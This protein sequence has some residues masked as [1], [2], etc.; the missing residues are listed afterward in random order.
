MPRKTFIVGHPVIMA[1]GTLVLNDH[2]RRDFDLRPVRSSRPQPNIQPRGG[3]GLAK[4]GVI[5]DKEVARLPGLLKSRS[6]FSRTQTSKDQLKPSPW[7][8]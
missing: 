4:V 8:K 2:V 5:R 6:Q 1:G 3:D 7:R